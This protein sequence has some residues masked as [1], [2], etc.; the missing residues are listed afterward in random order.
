MEDSSDLD[1]LIDEL[2][3]RRRFR[4]LEEYGGRSSNSRCELMYL[5]PISRRARF[6]ESERSVDIVDTES[7]DP[8]EMDLDLLRA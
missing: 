8:E 4:S 6:G 1:S 3:L 2:D 7:V 5:S